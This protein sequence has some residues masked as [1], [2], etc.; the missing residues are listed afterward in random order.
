MFRKLSR[1]YLFIAFFC[2]LSFSGFGQT[3][4]NWM[5]PYYMNI[6]KSMKIDYNK[7]SGFEEISYLECFDSIPRVENLL[8]CIATQLHS[9]DGQFIAFI[10]IYRPLNEGDSINIKSMF[11]DAIFP[12]VDRRHESLAKAGIELS[13]GKAAAKNWRKYVDYYPQKDA[14]LKFNADTALSYS[15]KLKPEDY[16]KNRFKNLKVLVLQKRGRGIVNFYCFYTDKAQ[17]N[18]TKYWKSIEGVFRYED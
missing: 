1:V 8:S 4:L 2:L 11:P 18:F 10:P 17:P 6:L 13:L 16:Y 3:S 7:P 15:I 5:E 14:V 9:D 12:G